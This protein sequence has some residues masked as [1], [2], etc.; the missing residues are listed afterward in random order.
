[1]VHKLAFIA[2]IGLTGRF[3][4]AANVE[5][6]WRNIAGGVESISTFSDN[7]LAASGLDVADLKSVPGF[8]PARGVLADA[9]GVRRGGQ[10]RRAALHGPGERN[11]RARNRT[12]VCNLSQS[13]DHLPI[14]LFCV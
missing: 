2:V 5:Q 1:M 12:L 4:G 6:Y 7:D 11:L 13:F 10:E 9:A 14:S 8:V 3:P